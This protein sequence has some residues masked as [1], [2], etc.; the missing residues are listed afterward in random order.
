MGWGLWKY[1]R[2]GC[3]LFSSHT[4]FELGDGSKIRFRYDVWC[5]ESSLR[6]AFSVLHIIARVKDAPVAVNMDC[7]S[8]F[9]Q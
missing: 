3:R 2:R 5:G 7:S 9:L 8:G 6:E 1:I 4:S